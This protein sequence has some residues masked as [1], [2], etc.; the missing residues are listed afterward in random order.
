MNV[1]S[2]PDLLREAA[3]RG[4]ENP[5]IL[6]GARRVSYGDL[7][8]MASG[9]A[10]HLRETGLR[11]GDRVLLLW[12][13]GPEYAAIYFGIL[14]A[15]G[16]VVPLNPANYTDYVK[17]AATN[18]GARFAAASDK[19]YRHLAGWWQGPAV[20]TGAGNGGKT[21]EIAGVLRSSKESRAAF[22]SGTD[23]DLALI[24]YTSGTTGK[25]KGVMLTHRNLLANT[26][27]ILG[28]L[29]LNSADRTLAILPFY[30]SY[31]NSLL[32]THAASGAALVVE[33]RFAF[34]NKALDTMRECSVTGLSG[35]PSHFSI[36]INRSRF[37]QCEW[38]HLR[39]LTCAGGGLPVVH[40]RGI[41]KAL[42]HVRLYV[43]YGQTEGTARL[44]SLDPSCLDAKTGS[45][46]KGIPG[47]ELRVVGGDGRDIRPGDT[48]ELIARGENV[49]SGY[50]GDPGG[51]REVLVDG[52]LHTGDLATVDDDGFIY[53]QGRAKEFIKTGGYRVSPQQVEEILL[54]HP[55]VAEC[56]VVGAPDDLLGERILALVVFRTEGVDRKTIV[57]VA[58]HARERLPSYMVPGAIEPI[59]EIPKTE[60]GKVRRM[61]LRN[62]YAPSAE[63]P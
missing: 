46:G 11:P 32:M 63:N 27:S 56:A 20:I 49:M 39:Y 47:V 15:G 51:T 10:S 12:E 21:I 30:Y 36:L 9:L 17:Y 53:I 38:P 35:V 23:D 1:A 25:P 54:Q 18:S 59:L 19:A 41:R 45:I 4:P 50:L 43:M 14:L 6:H 37:L 31:G 60:S 26:R 44:S 33:N 24:L 29:P 28:Y 22:Q 40:I 3:N 55:A 48:G 58:D 13:N 2:V 62:R 7:L 52:W 42:P 34:V 8:G 5:A 57:S 16:V 61:E